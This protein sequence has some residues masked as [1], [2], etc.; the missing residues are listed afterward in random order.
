MTLEKLN[1][2]IGAQIQYFDSTEQWLAFQST[3]IQPV[4]VVQYW[5]YSEELHECFVVARSTDAQIVYCESGF[6]PSFPWSSQRIGEENMGM[7][8]EWHAYLYE[9]FIS[10]MWLGPKPIG[11]D[12]KGPGDRRTT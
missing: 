9:S 10:G 11:F 5:D 8:A 4:R 2:I 6:G 3:R 7:D 12:F 1:S